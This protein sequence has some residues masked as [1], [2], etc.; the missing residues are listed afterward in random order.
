MHQCSRCGRR[1]P[2]TLEVRTVRRPDGTIETICKHCESASRCEVCG[3][4]SRDRK[5][6]GVRKVAGKW[7]V[8]CTKCLQKEEGGS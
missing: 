3:Y 7:R 6:F 8:L 2:T 4:S 1:Y 5:S